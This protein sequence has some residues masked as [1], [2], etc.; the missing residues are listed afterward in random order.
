MPTVP[1]SP[2]ARRPRPRWS[3][4]IAAAVLVAGAA[5][6]APLAPGNILVTDSS[7]NN[8]ALSKVFVIN[9]VTGAATELASAG[10]LLNPIG[11]AVRADGFAFVTNVGSEL[12]VRIDPAATGL[13]PV[14]VAIGALA[15]MRGIVMEPGGDSIVSSPSTDEIVRID[16]VTGTGSVVSGSGFIHF[17]SGL[18]REP[19]G[20]LVV[21]DTSTVFG[22]RILRIHPQDGSQEQITS[23]GMLSV[24]RDIEID[25]T[26]PGNFLVIDSGAR[27]VFRVDAT[28]PYDSTNPGANQFLWAACPQFVSPRGIAV[29]PGGS[30]LVSD[31]TTKKVYR[32]QQ[33]PVPRV[34][35][36]LATGS[37]LLGPWDV[38]VVGAVTPF[39][40]G[41]LLVADAG[42]PD[43]VVRVQPAVPSGAVLPSSPALVDPVAAIR[44]LNGDFFVL[45]SDRI[46][47]VTPAGVQT[48]ISVFIDPGVDLTGIVVD[49]N[50]EILVTDAGND[51]L[52][53]VIP[54]TGQ[55][56]VIADD[57]GTQAGDPLPPQL[58][59][60]AG[61]ALDG[62]GT[63]LIANRGHPT[64]TP[65]VPTG[66]V[67][68]NPISGTTSNVTLDPQFGEVIGV[69]LDSNG[70]YLIADE[71]LDTVWRLR[72][73]TPDQVL[74]YP[75]SIGNQIELL[76][77]ITVDVNRSILVSNQG[78]AKILRIDPSSGVQTLITAPPVAFSDIQ[79]I[80]LDQIPTPPP[81]DSDDD[82]VLEAVDNC[83]EQAN[84]DQL[85]TDG[86]GAGDAC[87]TDDDGDGDLDVAD[88]CRLV[89][90][91]NQEDANHEGFGNLCD[92]DFN[93]DDGVG[94]TDFGLFKL[95][96]GKVVPN[97]DPG[98]LAKFD[99]DSDGGI[100]IT[101]Y[102]LF[103]SLFGVKPGPSGLSCAGTAPCPAT[104]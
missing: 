10:F 61:L 71:E 45:R 100:G 42:T 40:P 47:R 103:R 8:P 64:E 48:E 69:A 68:V 90:N 89:V 66:I 98:L 99:L 84:P 65:V 19:S 18:V 88:N 3:I 11:V 79:G 51:R 81:L 2:P 16:S 63:A 6:G 15:N 86:D 29:E 13:T 39:A 7:G 70:D 20:D 25:P 87:D 97:P 38:T 59:A 91:P 96:F 28:I 92:A 94:L 60:P 67:R 33:A 73:S 74:L 1:A 49:A 32:I 55:Q 41:P 26:A 17:P 23:S 56:I 14:Q 46:Y 58:A 95:N 102:G 101:D 24:P 37:A 52:V 83:P 21:L 27:K 93:D 72:V 82:G 50:G 75:V 34:C 4:A 85:D 76:R 30:V 44:A 57:S 53:R 12:L 36:E 77:G 35:T 80:S 54:G 5:R 9:P 43:Q 78:T 62:N 31:F 22:T 104:P